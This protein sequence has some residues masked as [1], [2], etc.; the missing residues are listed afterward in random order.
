MASTVLPARRPDSRFFRGAPFLM[1]VVVVAGFAATFYGR[2]F[3]DVQPIAGYLYLHGAAMTLWFVLLPMQAWLI[4]HGGY[5]LHRKIGWIA[6]VLVVVIPVTA[7]ITQLSAPARLTTLLGN[8][9]AEPLLRSMEM[10]FWGNWGSMLNFIICVSAALWFRNRAST[11]K[12]MMIF[13]SIGLLPPAAARIA[14]WSMFSPGADLSMPTALEPVFATSVVIVLPL[15]LLLHDWRTRKKV[16]RATLV[17]FALLI[18]LGGVLPAVI[19][20]SAM[21]D[22]LFERWI[23]SGT[24]SE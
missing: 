14:R 4:R 21:G 23:Q 6:A 8:A 1:L 17:G 5:Q 12:R 10:P 2:A 16:H 9:S 22:A 3:F 11:H 24:N 18:V 13:A 15:F 19:A 7:A 20:N